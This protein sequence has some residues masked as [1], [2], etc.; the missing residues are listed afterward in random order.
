[1]TSSTFNTFVSSAALSAVRKRRVCQKPLLLCY[2][3]R[4]SKWI[5][6]SGVVYTMA[7]KNKQ[8]AKAFRK[9][10]FHYIRLTV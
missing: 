6:R 3:A 7:K 8:F 2:L 4:C 9:S 1:M 5:E 10:Q